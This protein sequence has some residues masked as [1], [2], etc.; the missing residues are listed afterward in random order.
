MNLEKLLSELEMP[1]AIIIGLVVALFYRFTSYDNG[2][3]LEQQIKTGEQNVINLTAEVKRLKRDMVL[4][5]KFTTTKKILGETFD[6]LIRYLPEDFNVN[7]QMK[8]IS[9]EAKTA[10]ANIVSIAKGRG[11]KQFQFYE[12]ISVKV[13]LEGTFTQVMMFLSRLTRLNKVIVVRD[14]TIKKVRSSGSEEGIKVSFGSNLV[15]YRYIEGKK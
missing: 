4:V 5:E 1:K 8:I 10:G 14:M 12:E 3:A 13:E 7:D 15:G 6:K 11:G 9:T 2:S